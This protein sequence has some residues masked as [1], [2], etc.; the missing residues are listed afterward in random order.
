MK[1]CFIGM[2]QFVTRRYAYSMRIGLIGLLVVIHTLQ[3]EKV[4]VNL[5]VLW[6]SDNKKSDL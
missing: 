3:E 5:G 1:I 6:C 2:L 4:L